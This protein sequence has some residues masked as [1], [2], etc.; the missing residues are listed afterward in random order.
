MFFACKSRV[1]PAVYCRWFSLLS[2]IACPPYPCD[3][4]E[5]ASQAQLGRQVC[6]PIL[7]RLTS[8]L[9]SVHNRAL[10]LVYRYTEQS[11]PRAGK[12]KDRSFAAAS[13]YAHRL[14]KVQ[15]LDLD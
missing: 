9:G 2:D 3:I 15:F 10:P 8:Y 12:T 4:P 5:I 13:S 14:K 6:R 11:E 7:G 1:F